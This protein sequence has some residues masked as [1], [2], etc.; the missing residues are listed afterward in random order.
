MK[1]W[2]W[3]SSG[4]KKDFKVKEAH[5]GFNNKILY[6]FLF[7]L[8]RAA[9]TAF[10]GSQAK[11]LIRATAASLHHCHSSARSKLCL[12][13]TPQLTAMPDP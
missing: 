1:Y 2:I 12:Q 4:S 6:F 8:F 10:G 9:P 13:L 3:I 5:F 7:C 11:G